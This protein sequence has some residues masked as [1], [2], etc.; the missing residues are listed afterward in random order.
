MQTQ[1]AV[2]RGR[3]VAVA[4]LA[5]LV[6]VMALAGLASA[7]GGN[8]RWPARDGIT[9]SD[10][11][12]PDDTYI[13]AMDAPGSVGPNCFDPVNPVTYNRGD[14]IVRFHDNCWATWYSSEASGLPRGA[15]INA[16]ADD[17]GATVPW[18]DIYLVF[19]K[20]LRVPGVGLVRPHDIVKASWVGG[21]PDANI[22]KDYIMIV[23]GSDV[24]LTQP[25]ER[26]DGLYVFTEGKPA[27]YD[28]CEELGLVSTTG[29]YS[30]PDGWGGWLSGDGEDVLGFCATS[31][32]WDT[33][34]QW[35]LYHDGSAEG[36]PAKSL[37][38]LSHESGRKA[39]DRF[40]FLTAG[41]FHVDTADGGHSQVYRFQGATGEYD[42]PSFG[43]PRATELTDRVD[44]FHIYY[45]Q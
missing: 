19:A 31:V 44:S 34:G 45:L 16:L 28:H 17:C 14:A 4:V 18:C 8:G 27:A 11:A 3:G 2:W 15:D 21:N 43:F 5:A 35:F 37:I 30:V 24:G 6:L 13:V 32:G 38:A 42:G 41:E 22:Y 20:N 9:P 12:G 29:A 33:A 10:V 36:M 26:L 25:G 23:D 39:F 1:R 40:N 7:Q